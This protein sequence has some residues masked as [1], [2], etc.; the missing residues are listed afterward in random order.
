MSTQDTQ[1]SIL[2]GGAALAQ[3]LQIVKQHPDPHVLVGSGLQ[4]ASQA[5]QVLSPTSGALP[6]LQLAN[7]LF[8]EL[9]SIRQGTP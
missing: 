5:V 4:L 3:F 9:E 8:Q 2:V 7:V 1:A 6:W